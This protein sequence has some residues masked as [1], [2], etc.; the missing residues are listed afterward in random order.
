MF[1]N[2]SE[3]NPAEIAKWPEPDSTVIYDHFI[4]PAGRKFIMD[5]YRAYGGPKPP[6]I[7]H[8]GI[9]SGGEKLRLFC[10]TTEANGSNCKARTELRTNRL[11]IWG[12]RKLAFLPFGEHHAQA[13]D[14][15][16]S[17]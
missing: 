8:Q 13:T 16:G 17:R 11:A 1:W 4:K 9:E 5:H 3:R 15:R 7:D 2:V 6:P 10:I 14:F 12:F